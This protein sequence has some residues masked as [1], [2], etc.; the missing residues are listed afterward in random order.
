[1]NIQKQKAEKISI[2]GYIVAIL[3]FS[4]FLFLGLAFI[5]ISIDELSLYRSCT[6]QTKGTIGEVSH[7]S[8]WKRAS[9][10]WFNQHTYEAYYTYEIQG[11]IL[12]D[13][14]VTG[15][16]IKE[17]Q[18]IVICYNSDHPNEKYVKGYDN[19]GTPLFLIIGIF[20]SGLSLCVIG[21][22]IRA[23][24]KI[25]TEKIVKDDM[26]YFD[27][28]F[29]RFLQTASDDF[30]FECDIAWNDENKEKTTV[31]VETD[32][33]GIMHV[34]YCYKKFK[35]LYKIKQKVDDEARQSMAEYFCGHPQYLLE[36]SKDINK[37]DLFIRSEIYW[38]G[39]YRNGDVSYAI[40]SQE[41][42]ADNIKVT[43]KKNGRKEIQ[44][45]DLSEKCQRT[46]TL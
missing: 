33:P 6:A 3:F 27:S 45:F 8:K 44:F 1:M 23:I 14:I 24:I 38:L 40:S 19:A 43:R 2:K 11:E 28:P 34:E 46:D 35:K 29:G 31:Y 13:K 10:H 18:T 16:K 20:F 15:K 5:R 41:V 7:S 12:E 21:I 22:I 9:R 32:K 37:Y 17:G 30:G 39:I 4:I 26:L 25:K 36:D 42:N